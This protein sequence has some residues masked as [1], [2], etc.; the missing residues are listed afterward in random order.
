MYHTV[1]CTSIILYIVQVSYCILYKYITV[2]CTSI[3]LKYLIRFPCYILENDAAVDLIVKVGFRDSN[4]S[5]WQELLAQEEVH[6]Q[7]KCDEIGEVSPFAVSL[8]VYSM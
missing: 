7:L 1:Y 3:K 4:N 5:D 2:C 6:R 8:S